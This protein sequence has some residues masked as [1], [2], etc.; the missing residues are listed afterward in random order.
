MNV[1]V[2]SGPVMIPR[3]DTLALIATSLLV[4]MPLAAW[5]ANRSA[6]LVLTLGALA[7]LGASWRSGGL[8][9]DLARL[10]RKL[11]SPVG[12]AML[13]FLGF[14][15][16]SVVWSHQP[17]RSLRVFGE[18]SVPLA[19]GGLVAL[20]WP[21]QRA[22]AALMLVACALT[23]ACALV[24]IELRT[25][26]ALRTALGMK[27]YSYIF[28]PVMISY[29]LLGFPVLDG[30]W[31]LK[32]G[33]ARAL[34]T[35]LAG[36]LVFAIFASESGAAV[37]GLIIGVL[38][39]L[40]ARLLPR[41]TLTALAVGFLACLALAPVM[42][43]ILDDTLPPAAHEG[44]KNAHSRDRVDIW[45]SFG[46]AARAR[47]LTG[48]GF[49]TSAVFDSHPVA[50][51]VSARRRVLLAVGHPHSLPV[52]IWAETGVIGALLAA[53]V[54]LCVVAGLARV[55]ADRR[56]APL[57]M[58]ATALAIATVGHGAWQAWWIAAIAASFC[59]FLRT[60][61]FWMDERS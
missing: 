31:R 28:N 45:L 24:I 52:Q 13:V 30:L 58:A 19:A 26:M 10:R 59:W 33:L 47:P 2:P 46:E 38:A 23:L 27:S 22:R 55:R 54:F 41:L 11:A 44:M 1:L 36:V 4:M 37:F 17:W 56:A 25:G 18:L 49:G 53:W 29:L 3:R 50:A 6:P 5:L 48:A 61:L 15:L 16:L 14:A 42:G 43:G 9:H 39:W 20:L 8:P 35:V 51:E 12:T 7:L 40:S 21:R 60:S 57:A 32:D 34:A